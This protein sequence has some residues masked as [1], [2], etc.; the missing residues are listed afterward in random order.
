MLTILLVDDSETFRKLL[1]RIFSKNSNFQIVGE[2]SSG[3][4]AL[5][6]LESQK[7]DLILLDLSMPDMDGLMFLGELNKKFLGKI[8]IFSG[9]PRADIE[10]VC[11]DKGA[12]I[13]IEKGTAIT[14]IFEKLENLQ[15]NE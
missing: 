6:F 15:K 3:S 10:Q 1:V 9:I 12:D 5:L 14:E 11:Y 4:E 13:Y 2:A 7:P 8:A